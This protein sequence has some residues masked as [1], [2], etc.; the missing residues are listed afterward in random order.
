[1]QVSGASDASFAHP[2]GYYASL[3]RDVEAG[4]LDTAVQEQIDKVNSE[5]S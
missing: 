1:M 5:L 4:E 3:L 2:L